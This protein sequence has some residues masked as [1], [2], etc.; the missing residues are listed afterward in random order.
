MDLL[1]CLLW[2]EAQSPG[3]P[4]LRQ[5]H[6][7]LSAGN[8]LSAQTPSAATWPAPSFLPLSRASR[9]Q[10]ESRGRGA[11]SCNTSALWRWGQE[12]GARARVGPGAEVSPGC[13]KEIGIPLVSC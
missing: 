11:P 9:P 6:P 4:G 7:D 8:S 12:G 1:S 2:G 3:I 5:P 10:P 13:W